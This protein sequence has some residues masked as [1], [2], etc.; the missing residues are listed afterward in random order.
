MTTK[1]QIFP[2]SFPTFLT[3]LAFELCLLETFYPEQ[4][5]MVCLKATY[6]TVEHVSSETSLELS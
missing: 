1:F 3:N 2:L 4:T 5:N 6:T